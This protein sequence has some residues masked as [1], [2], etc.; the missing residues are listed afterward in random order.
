[1]D[2]YN[3][4]RGAL[5]A[6]GAGNVTFAATGSGKGRP[7]STLPTGW[8]GGIRFDD[9]NGIDWELSSCTS[10]G[11]N[12]FSRDTLLA[13]ST[14]SKVNLAV[15]T[16]GLH[17]VL[18]EQLNNMLSVA[19][20]AFTTTIPLTR[21]GTSYMAPKTVT[22]PLAFT[23][24][25][26]AVRGAMVYLRLIADG[27][28]A[29]DTT[30]FKQRAGGTAYNNTAG[31]ENQMRF[32]FDGSNYSL[33]VSQMV[34]AS[35]AATALTLAGPT[36]GIVSLVSS[37]Y[38]V[39]LSP[40][41]GTATSVV[42][43]PSDSGG[44]G[45]FSPTSLTL[46]TASPSGAFTYTP[47]STG[48]KSI[49]ITN[50]ASLTNP[51]ALPYTVMSAAT[52]PGAPT[53]AA[54]K[55]PASAILTI[56][57]GTAGSSATTGYTVTLP[58]GAAD[59][60]NGTT[61]LTR[62]ITGLTPFAAQ[63]FSVVANSPDGTSAAGTSNSVAAD[64]VDTTAPTL[65]AG[66]I[67]GNTVRL[68]YSE[69]LTSGTVTASQFSLSLNGGAAVAASAISTMGST[70]VLTFSSTAAIGD[71]ATV[72]YTQGAAATAIRDAA[73]TPNLAANFSA[74]AIT[75]NTAAATTNVFGANRIRPNDSYVT[76]ASIVTT[77]HIKM[78]AEADFIGI[79][80]GYIQHTAS[81]QM[82]NLEFLYGVTDTGAMDTVL[83]EYVPTSNGV[84][85]NTMAASASE[86]AW[87][88]G[89][90]NN[91]NNI[92]VPPVSAQATYAGNV[93]WSDLMPCASIPRT[94]VVGGR[95][96]LV[97]RFANTLAGGVFTQGPSN[98][99]YNNGR[100]QPFYREMLS[101]RTNND[102]VNNLGNLPS[103]TNTQFQNE[104]AIFVEFQYTN[105]I[106][107]VIIT[108][109]SRKSAAFNTYFV[110]WELI[111]LRQLVGASGKVGVVNCCG[112][113]HSQVQF[114]KLVND[115]LDSGGHATDI[116]IPAFSQNG[117][118]TA[119]VYASN[120]QPTLDRC[121]A[122]GISIWMDTD[123]AV[124][125]YSP[126][127][128]VERQTC[129]SAARTLLAQG[130]IKGIIDID[131]LATDYGPQTAIVKDG[132]SQ[133][134]GGDTIHVG[135]AAQTNLFQPLLGLVWQ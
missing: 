79:R 45:T 48:A 104:M 30:A 113:G 8:Q 47:A 58:S 88:R 1:M 15:G 17:T 63:T 7:F 74:Q 99:S 54:K 122:A 20:I 19:D 9:P 103:G 80:V 2:H 38:S 11:S 89:T 4:I 27:A 90:W 70:A 21:P 106:R 53:V 24:A 33:V 134:Y 121:T 37:N 94:D 135:P 32:E 129:L 43:T 71:T 132:L 120:M 101:Y 60:D 117:F 118:T 68:L 42:V 77:E 41:G 115:F 95:P 85:K 67:T 91:G 124:T 130:K 78:E 108:G 128:E 40:T 10:L 59:A 116:I 3:A 73:P 84:S 29:P 5:T 86:V 102:A 119:A 16:I 109:D 66:T 127:K 87:H 62:T 26:A 22:G 105:P 55:A 56:T 107:N 51:A 112:S 65:V 126:S 72:S 100:G 111:A 25:A 18:A 57:P 83:H 98:A 35:V 110:S 44:G 23:P 123:Y 96:M 133:G 114:L 82:P 81:G 6:G 31:V 52:A 69:A 131:S 97:L 28:N 14:G 61:K 36:S 13:S 64:R 46:S 93:M 12:V 75:N 92:G 76:G 34:A 39:S 49:S 125:G 50:N